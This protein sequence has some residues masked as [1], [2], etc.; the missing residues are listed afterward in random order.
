MA[1]ML[2]STRLVWWSRMRLSIPESPSRACSQDRRTGSF[3]RSNSFIGRNVHGEQKAYGGAA[4][5][6]SLRHSMLVHVRARQATPAGGSADTPNR[7]QNCGALLARADRLH[8]GPKPSLDPL[9]RLISD[10]L[11]RVHQ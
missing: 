9:C 4:L 1:P 7:H 10:E 11:E 5:D 3:V 2:P 6:R 8:A